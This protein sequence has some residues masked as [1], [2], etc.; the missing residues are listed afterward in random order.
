MALDTNEEINPL[1]FQLNYYLN[2]EM[3]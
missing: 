2:T 1:V 3:F